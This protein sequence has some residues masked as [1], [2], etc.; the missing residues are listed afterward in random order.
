[1]FHVKHDKRRLGRRPLAEDRWPPVLGTI[2]CQAGVPTSR[3]RVGALAAH[4]IRR[5]CRSLIP[6][7]QV[8]R[9]HLMFH[10][11]LNVRATYA[12]QRPFVEER[13]FPFPGLISCQAEVRT[14]RV[15]G[16][17]LPE[18]IH[19]APLRLPVAGAPGRTTECFT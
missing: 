7:T 16:Q 6:A 18:L 15:N 8:S 3:P 5:R 10:V 2:S 17:R 1:M 9:Q 14:P 11:K 12:G 13:G 19:P 4:S